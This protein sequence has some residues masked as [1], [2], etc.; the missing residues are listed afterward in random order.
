MAGVLGSLA[1]LV[2][3]LALPYV[4]ALT[5]AGACFVSLAT[6]GGEDRHRHWHCRWTCDD[7]FRGRVFSVNDTAS[8]PVLRRCALF[9]RSALQLEPADEY[10]GLALTSFGVAFLSFRTTMYR[11]GTACWVLAPRTSGRWWRA[12]RSVRH[13]RCRRRR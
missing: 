3:A 11:S 9:L 2:P 5:V 10:L 8:Q 4:A 1:V 7:D 12:G 13:Q 6:Q